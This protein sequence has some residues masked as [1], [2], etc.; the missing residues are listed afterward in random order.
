METAVIIARFQTS[1]L[2]KGQKELI[3]SVKE[4][5]PKVIILLG[6]APIP[7]SKQN[8][9]DYSAR[10]KMIKD[11]DPDLS[12][13]PLKDHPSDLQWSKNIDSLLDSTFPQDNFLLYGSADR[14][15][16]SYRGK[17]SCKELAV[18]RETP[19]QKEKNVAKEKESQEFR[20]GMIFAYQKQYDKV[21]PTVD[22]A[23]FKEDKKQILLAKKSIN[24]KWRL[25]GGFSD[26]D[27]ASYEEAAMRELTEECGSI[28]VGPMNYETS[29][30]IED[31]R[32][33]FEADKII[34][35]LFSCNFKSGSVEAKDDIQEL[36]WFK[37]DHL[38]DMLKKDELTPEHKKLFQLLVSKYVD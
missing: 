38:A 2:E 33:R 36:Q 20:E 16:N 4:R 19:D 23:V 37:T 26:P 29:M 28:V 24:N 34:T 32:Y 6:V 5:H 17:Y 22:I 14:F 18:H 9:F 35:T 25:I 10:E 15:I 30:K 27:D 1:S 11:Y 21:Y 7:G 13:L 3:S 12:I 31:W 8:P